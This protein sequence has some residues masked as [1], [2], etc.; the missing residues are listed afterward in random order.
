MITDQNLGSPTTTINNKNILYNTSLKKNTKKQI[1][2][3][4]AVYIKK[5]PKY[6]KNFH[7]CPG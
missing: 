5:E 7:R 6:S 4:K 1:K 2:Q 3:I